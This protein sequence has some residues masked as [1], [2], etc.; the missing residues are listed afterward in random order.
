MLPTEC[1]LGRILG[2]PCDG[3]ISVPTNLSHARP[4]NPGRLQSAFLIEYVGFGP[5]RDCNR[6]PTRALRAAN[7]LVCKGKVC[8]HQWRKPTN[9]AP[10]SRDGMTSGKPEGTS[11]PTTS[12]RDPV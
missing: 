3:L 2:V 11:S 8:L 4:E 12:R 10:W 7:S 5:G 6:D 9:R 1:S